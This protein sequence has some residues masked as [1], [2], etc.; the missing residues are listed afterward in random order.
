ML[1]YILY[2]YIRIIFIDMEEIIYLGKL[3]TQRASQPSLQEPIVGKTF[4]T[5][6]EDHE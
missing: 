4:C 6:S 3:S 5:L 2:I 1:D